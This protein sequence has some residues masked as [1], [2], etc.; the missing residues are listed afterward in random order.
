MTPNMAIALTFV[1][2]KMETV[3]LLYS[4]LASK[5]VKS[6]RTITRR[7]L[8]IRHTRNTTRCMKIRGLKNKSGGRSFQI[9][10]YI[11]NVNMLLVQYNRIRI[12]SLKIY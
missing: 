6:R 8:K 4:Y 1:I 2:E 3:Y 9:F 5:M 10:F 12:R 7:Y 11:L